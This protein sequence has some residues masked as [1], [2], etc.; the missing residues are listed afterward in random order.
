[1]NE[2]AKVLRAW[3]YTF[4]AATIAFMVVPADL[5][6][7]RDPFAFYRPLIAT[8]LLYIRSWLLPPEFQLIALSFTDPLELY[9]IAS[10]VF[11]FAVSVPVLAY[12]I[13]RFVDPAL[14]PSERA[15]VYPFVVSFSLLF[16]TGSLFAFFVLLPFVM[17][18][19]I[20]FFRLFGL[21]L[22]VGVLDFY[23]LVFFTVLITGVAFTLPVF[24]V[25]LVKFGITGT[26]LLTRDRKYVWVGVF[27]LT[28]VI[29]PDGGPLADAA[30]FIPI[31]LLLEGSILVAKRYEKRRPVQERPA[32]LD[33]LK[34]RFCGG[35]IDESGVFCGRCGRSRL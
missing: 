24:L 17:F 18:G 27:I 5:S 22:L 25:L 26:R 33:A 14:K 4:V 32:E 12:E 10:V 20:L 8:I 9:V 1:M 7:L 6:F 28:A 16:V 13:Y 23:N 19:T 29:T 21:P 3:I 34:C 2:L 30:L 15:T 11:G 35:P 31:I